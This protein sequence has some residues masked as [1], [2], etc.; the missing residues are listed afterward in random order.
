LLCSDTDL[1]SIIKEQYYLA[2]KCGVGY[3]ESENM[4][5]FERYILVA[6]YIKEISDKNKKLK[7]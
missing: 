3:G 7:N 1:N 4:A 5:D 2:R 6:L